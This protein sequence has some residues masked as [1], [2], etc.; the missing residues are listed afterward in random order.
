VCVNSSSVSGLPSIDR[1]F[2][3]LRLS[4]Q[5][6]GLPEVA[7][8]SNAQVTGLGRWEGDSGSVQTRGLRV[9]RKSFHTNTNPPQSVERARVVPVLVE[10]NY[11]DLRG[12]LQLSAA[13]S[14][15][16]WKCSPKSA[17]SADVISERE[18]E[19]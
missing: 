10:F 16:L 1:A 9:Q 17:K 7:I 12:S 2:Q 19:V 5:L 4:A 6:R 13:S 18:E 15:G 8:E 11:D 3:A 14:E